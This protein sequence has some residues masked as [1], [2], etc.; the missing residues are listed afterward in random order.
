MPIGQRWDYPAGLKRDG[1]LHEALRREG[2]AHV[3]SLHGSL[4]VANGGH[5]DARRDRAAP[6]DAARLD[7]RA[8]VMR[9]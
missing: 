7:L 9:I 1:R 6:A 8:A 3:L 5:R 2:V 4:A